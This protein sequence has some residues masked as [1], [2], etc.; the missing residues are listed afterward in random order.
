MPSFVNHADA[1]DALG[2]SASSAVATRRIAPSDA[3]T[4]DDDARCLLC[5]R[6]RRR[7]RA[8]DE[9]KTTSPGLRSFAD[10]AKAFHSVKVDSDLDS[11]AIRTVRLT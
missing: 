10:D 4:K 3:T 7:S 8:Q 9:I 6:R 11:S 5:R 1:L 2:D